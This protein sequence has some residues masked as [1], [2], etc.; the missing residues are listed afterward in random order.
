MQVG[1]A[2]GVGVGLK[3]GIGVGLPPSTPASA[4]ALVTLFSI[5]DEELC[6]DYWPD[7]HYS[8]ACNCHSVSNFGRGLRVDCRY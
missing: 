4:G 6:T 7:R 5:T 3:I 8:G 1:E 2:V